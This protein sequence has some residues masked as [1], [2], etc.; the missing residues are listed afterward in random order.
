[1]KKRFILLNMEWT[2]WDETLHHRL[3]N[4]CLSLVFVLLILNFFNLVDTFLTWFVHLNSRFLFLNHRS[5]LFIN[6]LL[7]GRV[8]LAF[9]SILRDFFLTLFHAPIHRCRCLRRL[10]WLEV[11]SFAEVRLLNVKLGLLVN[12][13]PV[14]HDR[15]PSFLLFYIFFVKSEI[16]CVLFWDSRLSHG[17]ILSQR[18]TPGPFNWH[19]S[20][21]CG[22]SINLFILRRIIT[23]LR[24]N[25]VRSQVVSIYWTTNNRLSVPV[26]V[27]MEGRSSK[28]SCDGRVWQP[29]WCSSDLVDTLLDFPLLLQLFKPIRRHVIFIMIKLLFNLTGF[30]LT[31]VLS[32]VFDFLFNKVVFKHFS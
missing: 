27:V 12:N 5:S 28:V 3:R 23:R 26:T 15:V 29:P 21:K 17:H 31:I 2:K 30:Y 11:L 8:S 19:S 22:L 10:P 18:W 24:V 14:W 20:G 13:E 1:M 9:F 4:R 25:I 7:L 16:V 6:L 32:V